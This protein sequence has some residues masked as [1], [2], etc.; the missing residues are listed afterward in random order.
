V[1]APGRP[2]HLA[3]WDPRNVDSDPACVATWVAGGCSYAQD[4]VT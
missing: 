1:I 3:L 2:A 4:G